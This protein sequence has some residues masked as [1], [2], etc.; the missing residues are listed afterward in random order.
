MTTNYVPPSTLG[1]VGGMGPLASAEFLKT[2]YEVCI[3][4]R[5]QEA[6]IVFMY[7]NPTVPDRTECL[8]NGSREVLLESLISALRQLHAMGA[9]RTLICCV[10]IHSVVPQLPDDLRSK[11]ISLL[12]VI[13]EGV[14]Q[15]RQRHLLVCSTGT[16]KL[17]L[18]Q[19]HPSWESLSD[20]I[21]LP[22]DNDQDELHKMI[23]RVK[24]CSDPA[25][26]MP[27]VESLLRKYRVDSFIA[28]CTEIHLLARRFILQNG[29]GK[30][31][32]IDPLTIVAKQLAN[33]SYKKAQMSYR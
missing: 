13:Y 1:V 16:R 2:I 24:Q 10:T 20:Y 33:Q 7:S 29:S 19:D 17:G 32:C 26:A 28:G 6:P 14:E 5:E 3:G 4:G 22:D 25:D 11:L 31:G 27:Y 12:D 18:F 9:N 8:L 15:S 30:Y 21:V 23:Y